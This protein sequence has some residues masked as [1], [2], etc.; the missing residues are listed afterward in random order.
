MSNAVRDAID[1]RIHDIPLSPP[2]V[3]AALE[4]A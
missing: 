4:N 1:L 3:L 2:R